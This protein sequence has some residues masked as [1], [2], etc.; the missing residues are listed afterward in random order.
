MEQSL[1]LPSRERRQ[2]IV[3]SV[4]SVFAEKGFHGTTTRELAHAAGVSEA[5][6]YKHFPSKE[7]L[8]AAML[9]AC[10][11]GP[12]FE[13]FNRIL[14]LKPST[15]TLIHMIQ[16]TIGHFAEHDPDDPA[17]AAIH[18]L[19]ARSLLEDGEFVRLTHRKFARDWLRK[20][21]SSLKAAQKAGDLGE[22]TLRPDLCAWFVHHIAFSLMLHLRPK[23][24][25]IDYKASNQVLVDQATRFALLGVG[26]KEEAFERYYN[27]AAALD[28]D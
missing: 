28:Y 19:V 15:E 27:S 2:A 25:A 1:R 23:V 7:S 17:K 18:M 26:L 6:I 8:Y 13:E 16:F 9:D 3:E 12:A 24:P 11:K 14:S 10:A 20:F 21:E 4:T 22:T 5:L